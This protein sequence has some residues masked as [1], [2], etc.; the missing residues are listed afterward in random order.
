M[1]VS[2]W[3]K[4]QRLIA[5]PLAVSISPAVPWSKQRLDRLNPS[6]CL[7]HPEGGNNLLLPLLLLHRNDGAF[8]TDCNLFDLVSRSSRELWTILLGRSALREP[9]SGEW[10]GQYPLFMVEGF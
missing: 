7:Q 5:L 2:L 9:V 3:G 4:P 10:V 6:Y 8:G 1:N